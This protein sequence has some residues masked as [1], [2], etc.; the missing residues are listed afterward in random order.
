LKTAAHDIRRKAS[1]R[2]RPDVSEPVNSSRDGG[3]KDKA[4]ANDFGC[5][6]GTLNSP[7]LPEIASA[8]DLIRPAGIRKESLVSIQTR[9]N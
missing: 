6:A 4:A 7:T 2:N 1:D 8:P 3:T 5:C 9:V